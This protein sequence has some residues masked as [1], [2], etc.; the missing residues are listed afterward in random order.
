MCAKKKIRVG[1]IFGGRSGEHEVSLRSARSIMDALDPDKY[2]VLPIGITKAGRW[3]AGG[4]SGGEE[5]KLADVFFL[6]PPLPLGGALYILG[7]TNGEIRLFALDA[8]TGQLEWAQQLA[9]LEGQD[10]KLLPTHDNILAAVPD[11]ARLLARPCV[12]GCF[13]VVR[14]ERLL[15]KLAAE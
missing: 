13:N 15:R 1:V 14:A 3:I 8:K 7:E 10:A 2:D 9:L 5:P 12:C 4:E 6:G 11:C